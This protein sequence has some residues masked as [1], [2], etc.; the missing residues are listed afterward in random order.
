MSKNDHKEPSYID[1]YTFDTSITS[2][3][4]IKIRHLRKAVDGA[5]EMAHPLKLLNTR[6]QF[7][8]PTSGR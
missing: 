2:S 1:K 7:P 8:A 4:F 3:L 6:V 5:G